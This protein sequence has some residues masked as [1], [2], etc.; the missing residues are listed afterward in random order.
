MTDSRH[1]HA[2]APNLL[3]RN[4]KTAAPDTVWLADLSARQCLSDQGRDKARSD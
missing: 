3:D 1:S 4:F 2:I